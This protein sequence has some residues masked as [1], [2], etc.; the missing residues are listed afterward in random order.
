MKFFFS[1]NNVSRSLSFDVW[2]K[3]VGHIP[4]ARMKLLHLE[5]KDDTVTQNMLCDICPK[6][7]QQR[8]SFH[9]STITTTFSFELI[10]VDTRRPFHTK[11]HV[12]HRFLLTHVDDYT[13]DT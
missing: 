5:I 13:R 11:A 4:Y 8:L 9:L 7:K 10:Y 6:V 1:C 12:G 2:Y 3:R